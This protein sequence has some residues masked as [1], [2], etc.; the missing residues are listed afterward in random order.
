MYE[1]KV[2]RRSW[3]YKFPFLFIFGW[4]WNSN[5]IF[6]QFYIY[7]F[8]YCRYTHIYICTVFK[9][10]SP[11][12]VLLS[13]NPPVAF[14]NILNLS[15]SEFHCF[16]NFHNLAMTFRFLRYRFV[17]FLSK[18]TSRNVRNI[19]QHGNFVVFVIPAL[20]FY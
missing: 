4:F 16:L 3:V 1:G 13:S 14:V 7:K 17:S 18:D 2:D 12:L 11:S 8:N 20:I 10:H 5:D 15:L 19:D 6:K 9:F